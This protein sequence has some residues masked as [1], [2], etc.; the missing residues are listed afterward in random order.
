MGWRVA[1][2]CLLNSWGSDSCLG[3]DVYFQELSAEFRLFNVYDPYLNREVYWD[4]FF[5]SSLMTHDMVILGGYLNFSLGSVESWGP[6][7]SLDP[8]TNFFKFHR[9]QGDLIDLDPIKLEPTWRNHRIGEGHIAKRLDQFLVGDSIVGSRDFQSRQWVDWGGESEHNQILLEIRADA[10]KPPSPFKFNVAWVSDPYFCELVKSSCSPLVVGDGSRAGFSFMENL[11]RL[12]KKALIWE[13]SKKLRE[14]AE[15]LEIEDWLNSTSGS[16]SSGFLSEESKALLM[17][18]EKR[19]REILKERE[20]LWRLKSRAIWLSS[21]DDKKKLFHAYAKGRKA[22]NMIWELQDGD[23]ISASSSKDY[24][25]WV[26]STLRSYLRH[27]QV[28]Q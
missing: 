19:H 24:L 12:K 17:L 22:H 23:G 8:L 21:G 5:S 10:R 26:L 16:E 11:K 7:A 9:I 20:A 6:R 1:S 15:L 25:I 27:N 13:K 18:K 28:H 3:T 14:D 4:K 2:C